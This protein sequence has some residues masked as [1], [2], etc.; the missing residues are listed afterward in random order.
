MEPGRH[1]ILVAAIFLAAVFG[2]AR[3]CV[4][5]TDPCA[6]LTRGEAAALLG[7]DVGQP[8]HGT[9][10]KCRYAAAGGGELLVMPAQVSWLTRE[11]SVRTFFAQERPGAEPAKGAWDR[12][13]ISWDRDDAPQTDVVRIERGNYLLEL[14][15]SWKR[16]ADGRKRLLRAASL[17][18][19]RLP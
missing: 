13:T 3:E 12:A 16:P 14:D 5:Q 15:V 6:L 19:G 1:K 18:A 10:G 11:I 9:G 7:A 8:S 17:A 2:G 4:A